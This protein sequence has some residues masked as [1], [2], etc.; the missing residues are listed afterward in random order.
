[1]IVVL[2][3]HSGEHPNRVLPIEGA[4][5]L[6]HTTYEDFGQRIMHDGHAWRFGLH[7]ETYTDLIVAP[8]GATLP[9]G[10]PNPT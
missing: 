4:F 6:H 5:G 2:H 7:P 1:M 10:C 3:D 9:C 8:S